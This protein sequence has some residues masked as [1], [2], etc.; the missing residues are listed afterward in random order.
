M[1][2]VLS[3]YALENIF[4]ELRYNCYLFTYLFCG[5]RLCYAVTHVVNDITALSLREQNFK[6]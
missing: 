1:V 2:A 5:S 4:L 6:D 3:E